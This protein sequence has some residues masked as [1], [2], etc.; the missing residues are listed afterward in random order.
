M[1]YVVTG[2]LRRQATGL[3]PQRALHRVPSADMHRYKDVCLLL[4]RLPRPRQSGG[5]FP[6]SS[7]RKS[8]RHAGP[9]LQQPFASSFGSICATSTA[10]LEPLP[11]QAWRLRSCGCG[12]LIL[13]MMTTS[14]HQGISPTSCCTISS[15]EQA[16]AKA[17]M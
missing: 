9:G 3:I 6:D 4:R 7:W 14:Y 16:S 15:F 2:L 13:I 17:L 10:R 8:R 12:S 11:M 1:Q 5:R